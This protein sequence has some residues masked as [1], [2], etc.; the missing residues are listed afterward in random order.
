MRDIERYQADYVATYGFERHM[1]RLRR[2]QILRSLAAYSRRHILE[3]GCGLEPLFQYLDGWETYTIV[4]PSV[5]FATHAQRI[6]PAGR[7]VVVHTAFIEEVTPPL[8]EHPF[9]VILLSS[10]LHEVEKPDDLLSAIHR[11]CDRDTLVHVNV[12]NAQSLHNRLAV[13]M[14]LIPDVFQRSPLAEQ[15]QRRHTFDLDRMTGLVE[16]AGFRVESSG[17][18]FLKPFTHGQL[19]RMLAHDIIDE[20]VLDALFEI[21]AEFDG[22]GAELYVNARL[23]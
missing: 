2:R 12:P 14:G 20:R 4:E 13:R 8:G 22:L 7:H 11:L 16:E 15:L 21:N 3:V 17:T 19:E 6:A 10:L 18:Y 5:E 1:V 23:R 9:D